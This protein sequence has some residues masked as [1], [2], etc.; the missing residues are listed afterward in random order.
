MSHAEMGMVNRIF[1]AMAVCRHPLLYAD[2][3]M[4]KDAAARNQPLSSRAASAGPLRRLSNRKDVM[5][6]N[7][8]A[9]NVR[10]VQLPDPF[11]DCK[12]RY[13]KRL[14]TGTRSWEDCPNSDT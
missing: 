7:S 14:H 5:A 2:Y 1:V 9:L 3:L 10:L 11:C 6:R 12:M 13:F 4:W 8:G